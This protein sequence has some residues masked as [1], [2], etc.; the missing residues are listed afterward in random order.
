MELIYISVRQ[1]VVR[2]FPEISVRR[3]AINQRLVLLVI[4]IRLFW[5][6]IMREVSKTGVE[7][8]FGAVSINPKLY[9]I[10]DRGSAHH[11]R[12]STVVP[13][14]PLGAS[15]HH[16]SQSDATANNI[17]ERENLNMP[18]SCTMRESFVFDETA[19]GMAQK[20]TLELQTSLSHA[21]Q[22]V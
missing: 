10:G 21:R 1:C 22:R 6:P 5:E 7:P 20:S 18:K 4:F 16:S 8:I 15:P 12:W 13:N 11:H 14:Q 19:C 3:G 2:S 9:Q 17:H